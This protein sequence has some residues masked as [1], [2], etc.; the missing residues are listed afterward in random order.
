M[1]GEM[2]FKIQRNNHTLSKE[3]RLLIGA[4]FVCLTEGVPRQ[5]GKLKQRTNI[6]PV[7]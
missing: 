4:E 2:V 5:S 3:G 6:E 7:K 1:Q